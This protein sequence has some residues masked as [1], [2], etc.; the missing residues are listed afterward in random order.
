MTCILKSVGLRCVC[1]CVYLYNNNNNNNMIRRRY[2]RTRRDSLPSRH[3]DTPRAGARV[4]VIS[5]H[6]S[7]DGDVDDGATHPSW[8]IFIK[9]C[10]PAGDSIDSSDHLEIIIIIRILYIY[11]IRVCNVLFFFLSPFFF[12]FLFLIPSFLFFSPALINS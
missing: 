5:Y 3:R 12:F 8:I 10:A 11:M 2:R 4:S 9:H 7:N 1:V 6:L